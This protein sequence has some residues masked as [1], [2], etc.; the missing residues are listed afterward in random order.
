MQRLALEHHANVVSLKPN[1]VYRLL[2]KKIWVDVEIF[3]VG[4]R[5]TRL[6]AELPVARRHV[7]FFDGSR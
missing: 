1:T 5:E 3:L 7:R 6:R 2:P 4:S